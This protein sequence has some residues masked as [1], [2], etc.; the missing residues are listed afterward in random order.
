MIKDNSL[1]HT[2]VK[3]HFKHY[4]IFENSSHMLLVEKSLQKGE[5]LPDIKLQNLHTTGV[6][7]IGFSEIFQRKKNI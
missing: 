2:I 6:E 5:D 4:D 7:R 1:E 3:A